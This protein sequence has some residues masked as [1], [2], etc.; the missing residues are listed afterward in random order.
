[1]EL[2]EKRT[3]DFSVIEYLKTPPSEKELKGILKKLGMKAE[4]IVR[5]KESLFKEKFQG[6]K[7][8]DD[9]WVGILAKNPILIERPIIV[10]GNKA[11]IGRP[12]E[13]ILKLF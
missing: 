13:N 9:Q 1:M 3:K 8:S 11:V 2:I 12:T 4:D 6:K 5:K 10:K 7:F